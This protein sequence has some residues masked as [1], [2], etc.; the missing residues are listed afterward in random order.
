MKRTGVDGESGLE[1]SREREREEKG[2]VRERE[3]KKMCDR[4]TD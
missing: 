2:Q 1:S 4:E 3:R